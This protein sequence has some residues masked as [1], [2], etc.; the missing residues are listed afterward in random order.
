MLSKKLPRGAGESQLSE[1]PG[2]SQFDENRVRYPFLLECDAQG[3]VLWMDE[4]TRAA[5][6][7]AENL[8]DAIPSQLDGSAVHPVLAELSLT[9]IWEGGG[10][11][12]LGARPLDLPLENEVLLRLE[13]NLLRNFIR[14]QAAERFLSIR[15]RERRGAGTGNAI[16]QIEGERQRLGRELHTSVG[17]LLSAIRL[18]LE[19]VTSQLRQPIPG[20]QQALDRISILT[21]DA[22]ERVRSISQRLHPPEWQRFPIETA[23]QQMWELSGIPE[24]CEARMEIASLPRQPDLD[25]KVLIY[26]AAQEATANI[27]RHSRATRVE[28]GLQLRDGNL[29]LRFQ[30]N[31]A[32]FDAPRLFS[33]A[34]SLAGGIGL[35][36]IR[37]QAEALGGTLVVESGPDGTKLELT[38]PFLPLES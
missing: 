14:L 31:G 33:S 23:V 34:P 7:D 10:R 37:E 25:T 6:G 11:V 18:Q 16:Q 35:R 19:I 32:G 8:I 5:L 4:N 2:D 27:I 20:V 12:L 28:A 38:V 36:T 24:S 13:G 26:R 17:Q 15:V 3:R 21:A 22:L 9:R 30:D 29:V 1:E